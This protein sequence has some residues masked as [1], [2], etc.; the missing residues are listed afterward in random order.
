MVA[1]ALVPREGWDYVLD[2]GKH[3]KESLRK[4]FAS[5]KPY[6][7]W[8]VTEKGFLDHGSKIFL[9]R[10]LE[11][12]GKMEELQSL[13][14]ENRLL[15]AKDIVA[16]EESGAMK[17]AHREVQ[18]L[19][20]IQLEKAL[21]ML[22]ADVEVS[23]PS[24]P[25]VQTR[26]ER[27]PRKKGGSQGKRFLQHCWNCGAIAHKIRSCPTRPDELQIVE[28]EKRCR[29]QI[30]CEMRKEAKLVTHLKYVNLAQR[31]QSYTDKPAQR[32]DVAEKWAQIDMT[33]ASAIELCKM[34]LEVGLLRS[35]TGTPC[36][37]PDCEP[38]WDRKGFSDLSDT[39]RS[40]NIRTSIS[41]MFGIVAYG[42]YESTAC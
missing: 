16:K 39:A 35:L 25:A 34:C 19:H 7:A 6:L 13:G 27:N 4:V 40:R 32:S 20:A 11:A 28:I 3:A 38:R 29:G 15:K 33:R 37:N 30:A 5:D 23:T 24:V 41:K 12:T 36:V 9:K 21:A 18:Q 42:V 26:R 14:N 1:S 2:F 22:G 10:A 31:S 8:C 17:G